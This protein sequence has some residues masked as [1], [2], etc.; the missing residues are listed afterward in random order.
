ME[1]VVETA[2]SILI[3]A[4]IK[5][6]SGIADA[7]VY[8][9]A[10]TTFGF[11]ALPM[12]FTSSDTAVGYIPAQ[13]DSTEIFY[14][15]SATSSSGRTVAKPF[16]APGGFYKF[17]VENSVTDVAEIFNP[18]EFYLSQNYPNPFNP[19]TKMKFTIPTPPS[20]SPLAK[21]RNEVGFVSLKVYDIL[22]NEVASLVNEEL[23]A[24]VYEVEF[25]SHSGSVQ[26]LPSGVYFYTLRAG[27][28]IDSKKMILLK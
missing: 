8:W 27:S 3:E 15:I 21:G 28:F 7:S 14:Y 6:K 17:I 22:G 2:D 24:G 5:T 19:T 13:S 18:E 12:Q 1:P 26:N 20:S 16:V 23:P 11:S 9:T 10:D 4:V 25:D